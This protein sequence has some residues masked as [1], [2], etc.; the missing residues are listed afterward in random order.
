MPHTAKPRIASLDQFRG[1]TVAGMIL[2]NFIGGFEAVHHLE[3]ARQLRQH[4]REAHHRE[5]LHLEEQLHVLRGEARAA[6]AEEAR[7]GRQRA[8]LRDDRRRV[9]IS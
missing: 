6:H 5:L 3:Q 2:V 7:V 9:Q 4:L 8:E 1:Y